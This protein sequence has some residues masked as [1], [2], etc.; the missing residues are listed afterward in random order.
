MNVTAQQYG[1]LLITYLRPQKKRAV[2]LGLV[3]L[4]GIGLQLA[5]PQ[6][7]RLFI[8]AIE[9]RSA[10]ST[11]TLLALAFLGVGIINQISS[12]F[13]TWQGAFVGWTATNMLRRDLAEHCL[14]LEMSFH[15]ERTPGELIERIDGD[16]T[17]L[18][19]FFSQFLLRLLAAALLIV[20]VVIVLFIE[21][22]RMG[23]A[24]SGY[25]LVT[26]FVLVRMK[27]IA[28]KATEEEREVNAVLYGFLEERLAGIEDIR[29]N[30]GGPYAL[31]R[32]YGILRKM[33]YTGR[34]AW[35]RRSI[36]WFVLIAL[37]AVGDVVALGFGSELLASGAVTIGMVFL[38]YQYAQTM[39][40]MVDRIIQQM[41]DLQKAGA[42]IQRVGD[43]MKIKPAMTEG[44]LETMP[45]GPLSLEFVNVDFSYNNRDLILKDVSFRL[46]P[47]TSLGL[48]GRTGSGKTT[49]T[50]LLFR[51]YDTTSGSILI[52][53]HDPR[54]VRRDVLRNHVAMVTQEVQLFHASVR[55]NL[56]FFNEEIS[57][58]KIMEVIEDLG[59]RDW[60]DTLPK[61]LDTELSAGGGG[62]SAGE[63]QLL[64]FT[65]VFLRD[66]GLIVLDEPSSRLDPATERLLEEAMSRLLQNR[67]AIIIAHRLA[68][69]QRADEI[70]ILQDGHVLEHDKRNRL[71]ADP[72]SRF[73]ELLAKGLEKEMAG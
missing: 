71:I 18:A 15:N 52:G 40:D 32:L 70:M 20:G 3:I 66:P 50:R 43:L 45:A 57:D 64:A 54:D 72:N 73:N 1:S 39:W 65:R 63:A 62:L 25:A 56:T 67:T 8:D 60:L 38:F 10:A 59:L 36:F 33:L 58:R 17:A 24:V 4:V 14:R 26:V 13:S 23:V 22:W 48:L 6:I 55:D 11:L 47:G 28:I 31:R 35:M 44:T 42:A 69:V 51:L 29:A 46:E 2:M 16:I 9:Q 21:D 49:L 19:N 27:N 7:L 5:A 37:F 53:G 30:G 12:I 41:Q 68:T 34:R 61:G